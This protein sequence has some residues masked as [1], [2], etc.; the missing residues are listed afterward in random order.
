MALFHSNK[1]Y[2]QGS[3]M[4]NILKY[5]SEVSRQAMNIMK[6]PAE[7][8][9]YPQ[10]S[11]RQKLNLI[12]AEEEIRSGDNR[13]SRDKVITT[14]FDQIE[15]EWE[16]TK[17][18]DGVSLTV[19]NATPMFMQN[20][21][22]QREIMKFTKDLRQKFEV[23]DF[24]VDGGDAE[25]SGNF[26]LLMNPH[27]RIHNGDLYR[28]FNTLKRDGPTIGLC[29][30]NQSVIDEDVT[31]PPIP[32]GINF[33]SLSLERDYSYS[34][35]GMARRKRHLVDIACQTDTNAIEEEPNVLSKFMQEDVIK[36][37]FV[38]DEIDLDKI[39]K[40]ENEAA[41]DEQETA[42]VMSDVKAVE[43]NDLRIGPDNEKKVI[44][45]DVVGTV[46]Q[47]EI[48]QDIKSIF[49]DRWVAP[50]F[51]EDG[52][53]MTWLN[54]PPANNLD[55]I[56]DPPTTV[57]GAADDKIDLSTLIQPDSPPDLMALLN[58]TPSPML[59]EEE[60]D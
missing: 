48:E 45:L 9:V 28:M 20:A 27:R 3:L 29:I 12:T 42:L 22:I 15:S 59:V 25:Y 58:K 41:L 40:I 24:E 56:Q 5:C 7:E 14:Y 34:N 11:K 13:W 33:H 30:I 1:D 8:D 2:R 23:N 43:V 32:H 44:E 55:D 38:N 26:I 10:A 57:F 35:T 46:E 36:P 52:E 18:S 6:R 54:S 4:H 50:T 19:I 17:E 39:E 47:E 53:D 60:E 37:G 21:I 31:Q 16:R 51:N 49:T